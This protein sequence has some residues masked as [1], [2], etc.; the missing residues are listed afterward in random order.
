MLICFEQNS[1]LIIIYYYDIIKLQ[2]SDSVQ[3]PAT[4][5]SFHCK[6]SKYYS[7]FY[8]NCFSTSI[9]Q[10]AF[11]LNSENEIVDALI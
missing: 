1:L 6:C 9:S 3:K 5:K 7:I 2:K 4:G 10:I 8:G 11:T